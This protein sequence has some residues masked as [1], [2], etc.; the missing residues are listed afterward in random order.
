MSTTN[1][2]TEDNPRLTNAA[3]DYGRGLDKHVYDI[4]CLRGG[5]SFD[6]LY[7]SVPH[8]L[9]DGYSRG[10]RLDRSL[11]RLRNAGHIAY[12]RKDKLWELAK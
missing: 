12:N 7:F 10:R 8:Y 5:C 2:S 11:Q 9:L 3:T 4:I 1:I 6:T